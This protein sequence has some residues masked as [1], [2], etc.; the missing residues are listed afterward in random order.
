[1]KNLNEIDF[2]FKYRS[3]ENEIFNDFYNPC[4]E[5]CTRY[6][7]AV[8]YFT[9]SSLKLFAKGL[10]KFI[11]SKGKIRMITNP[12][13][14]E[15]DI[16]AIAC[17]EVAKLDIIQKRLLD[18]IVVDE[19]SIMNDTLNILAWLISEEVLEIKIAYTKN[20]SIYHEKFG[21]FY[22]SN[23]NCIMFS[24]SANETYGGLSNNF[25]KIDVFY[26]DGDRLRIQDAQIDF[27]NLWSN[28]TSG[29]DII[30]FPDFL[31]KEILQHKKEKPTDNSKTDTR[32]KPRPYQDDAIEAFEE[33]GYRGILE[34]ATGT[35]KTK[36][37]LYAANRYFKD[38]KRVFVV[39]LVP[40]IH[41][42]QQ[43]E[44]ECDGFGFTKILRCFDT[45]KKWIYELEGLVS[46]F[47]SKLIDQVI[48]IAVYKSALKKSFIENISQVKDN[49][50]LIADECHYFGTKSFVSSNYSSIKARLGLSATPQRWWDDEGT[51]YL[52]S[53]F[54]G[55]VYKFSLE[56]AIAGNFLTK[57]RY[58]PVISKLSDDEVYEYESLT[59]KI[60]VYLAKKDEESL[61]KAKL[62]AIKRKLIIAKATNKKILLRDKLI[63]I[64]RSK[65]DHI[66]V[67][68]APTEVIEV[69]N[70]IH[71]CGYTA[72]KFDYEVNL[73]DRQRIL[74]DFDLGN[75]QV[76]VAIKCLDEGVDIPSTRTAFFLASTS[77][78]KEFV[79]R[80]GRIL[81][82]SDNKDFSEIYDFI[83]FPDNSSPEVQLDVLRKEFPRFA[84]FADMAS[85]KYEARGQVVDSLRSIN[86]EYLL[87]KLPWEV[88]NE[89]KIE[90]RIE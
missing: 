78:P 16:T 20:N 83:V 27:E 70:L 89:D 77:N 24:G 10:A 68:C 37:S 58:Y 18:Q 29:L 50:F 80:R 40:F 74:N 15:E 55:V 25:E 61:E 19:D 33:N 90:R 17:G 67:Y 8:G 62:L 88:Y 2:K 64:E 63:E 57:Y 13:L 48:I 69:T 71:D 79:Q 86:L 53:Y 39:I 66:L 51:S 87:D 81:R 14:E 72:S 9:S 12:R 84:E 85:N 34:M 30:E 36:T 56:Q 23:D 7:R 76:L 6:D 65:R 11:G 38:K 52:E 28:N 45:E 35:G 22:D 4:L 43:W 31:K 41:L 44:K 54:S 82:K 46:R 47:N 60:G 75:I 42:V 49:S 21:L 3:D 73:E 1:M 32:F 5:V 59:K 26:G